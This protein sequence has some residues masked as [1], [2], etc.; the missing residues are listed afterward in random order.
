MIRG[1]IQTVNG[2]NMIKSIVD[3][4][5]EKLKTGGLEISSV[6]F[7]ELVNRTTGA[8]S[9]PVANISV[10][11]GKFKKIT[12]TTFQNEI[13]VS[14]YLMVQELRGEGECREIAGLL[15]DGITQLLLMDDLDETLQEKLTPSTF[16]NVTDQKNS[17][18]GYQIY[19][20]DWY[21]SYNIT[22][23]GKDEDDRGMLKGIFNKYYLDGLTQN[24]TRDVSTG[25]AD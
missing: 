11:S 23:T 2:R 7:S 21:C 19:K 16:T 9:K 5:A 14:I 24:L 6:D 22:A 25:D 20:F 12:L 15:I 8:I 3:K 17:D 1:H 4:I 10:N 13:I 18:A